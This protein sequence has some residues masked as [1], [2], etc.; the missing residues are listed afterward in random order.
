MNSNGLNNSSMI[1]E[2]I[3]STRS[4]TN[5]NKKLK[6]DYDDDEDQYFNSN[7][8]KTE[9]CEVNAI[10]D[11]CNAGEAKK[12]CF[13]C[14]KAFHDACFRYCGVQ[15]DNKNQCYLCNIK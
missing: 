11:R 1:G 4:R 8:M 12:R 13:S 14:S 5:K 3:Y 2:S 15:K 9:K 7:A 6:I 10:C